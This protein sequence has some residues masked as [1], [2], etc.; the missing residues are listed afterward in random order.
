MKEMFTPETA[1]AI[2][3][4]GDQCAADMEG[5]DTPSNLAEVACDANR[6]TTFGHP[7]ADKEVHQ[8]VEKHGWAKVSRA[9]ARLF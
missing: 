3:M 8:L 9:A 2:R 5:A 4:V 6:L 1:T 7:A